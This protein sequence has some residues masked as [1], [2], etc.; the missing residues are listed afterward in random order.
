MEIIELTGTTDASGDLTI[1]S[2][3]R[4]VGYV[5]K[6]V[7]DY[8]T[9]DTGADLTLTCEAEIS[10][11]I[12]VKANLGTSDSVFYPRAIPNK[13]A[14]GTAFTDAAEKIFVAGCFKAVI[15][16]GGNALVVR[17]LVYVSDE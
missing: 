5:E 13:V 9:A 17:F 11:S 4:V 6:V 12:L 10:E 15:A 3:Q 7:H 2:T 14:D 8:K 16:Q 1:T